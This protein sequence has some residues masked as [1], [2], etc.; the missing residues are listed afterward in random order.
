M[1]IYVKCFFPC[2]NMRQY[3]PIVPISLPLADVTVCVFDFRSFGFCS[4]ELKNFC[5]MTDML[6]P[7]LNS[8]A[9]IHCWTVKWHVALTPSMEASVMIMARCVNSQSVL[10]HIKFE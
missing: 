6:V 2:L 3:C 10:G 5:D 4:R 1:N 9:V 7:M 8:A